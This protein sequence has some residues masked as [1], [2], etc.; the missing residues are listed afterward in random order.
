MKRKLWRVYFVVLLLALLASWYVY[1]F[2]PYCPRAAKASHSKDKQKPVT[3]EKGRD[4]EKIV[5]EGHAVETPEA[6]L[7]AAN[8]A[9]VHHHP[10]KPVT[11]HQPGTDM[12]ACRLLIHCFPEPGSIYQDHSTCVF[13]MSHLLKYLDSSALVHQGRILAFVSF[14]LRRDGPDRN[15]ILIY[16]VCVDPMVRGHGFAKR[17]V[18]EGIEDM[19]TH[20]KLRGKRT[21]LG[22]DVD[23]TS[24]MA[25]ESFSLYT[26][27]G[28]LRG[29]QPC[30]SVGD[31]DW[32]AFFSD[33]P[34]AAILTPFNSILNDLPAYVR[35]EVEGRRPASRFKRLS[36][37]SAASVKYDH[38][39]MFK[40]YNESWLAIGKALAAPF[41][42]KQ[43]P[44]QQHVVATTDS[45]PQR[46][47][48]AAAAAA[49]ERE[50]TL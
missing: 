24:A 36:Q 37:G 16:N 44:H 18:G 30:P 40:W 47:S 34:H 12:D 1:F 46:P 22:L 9:I 42:A 28:Y 26:K 7:K 17:L 27:L 31:V 10:D 41:R 4:P 15:A 50:F 39:C 23:M 13:N 14:H 49:T 48:S 35:D 6:T 19:M 5:Q 29:W 33:P 32:R 8:M 38:Y 20:H 45:A 2:H 21:L 25:A 43:L 3:E 11:V